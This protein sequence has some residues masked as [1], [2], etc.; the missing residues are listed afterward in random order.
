ME[1]VSFLQVLLITRRMNLKWRYKMEK[2]RGA[3]RPLRKDVEAARP[4]QQGGNNKKED[5]SF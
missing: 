4:K 1:A 2:T 3:H 5:G